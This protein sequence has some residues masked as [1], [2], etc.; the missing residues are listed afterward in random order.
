MTILSKNKTRIMQNQKILLQALFTMLLFVLSSSTMQSQNHLDVE[1]DAWVKEKLEL[2]TSG[3]TNGEY[4]WNPTGFDL[5]FFTGFAERLRI[6]GSAEGGDIMIFAMDTI[7]SAQDTT[8]GN[9]V[10]LADGTLALRQY[11]I[12]DLAQGGIVFWVDETGEH[13]LVSSMTDL[14]STA[15]DS[16]HQW[17][18]V[19]ENTASTGDGIGAGAMNTLLIVS[20]QRGDT[21]S[22]ARL[23]ADLEEEGY[24]DWYL[25]SKEE[26]N[27]MWENLADSDGDGTNTGPSDPNNIGGFAASFYWSSSEFDD[28]N[29]WVQRFDNVVQFN[30]DKNGDNHV[31]AIRAF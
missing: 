9:V 28:L 14:E 20:A 4:I 22:A 18:A 24:G 25:P 2:N 8:A 31:R 17:S 12:G 11:K 5:Q 29:G 27:L 30:D 6:N 21:D 19:F 23:C 26:L 10:R 15:G 3:P 16:S 13:G 7:T 1:G